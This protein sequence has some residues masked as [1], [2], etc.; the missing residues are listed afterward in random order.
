MTVR[1][2]TEQ[3]LEALCTDMR[4][5]SVWMKTELTKR[6]ECEADETA[7]IA[8]AQRAQNPLRG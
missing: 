7:T 4:E 2:L 5:A 1:L 8:H 3:E 6:R